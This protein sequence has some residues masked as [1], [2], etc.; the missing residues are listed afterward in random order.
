MIWRAMSKHATHTWQ[1][2]SDR[3][4]EL[5]I[6]YPEKDFSEDGPMVEWQ[7]EWVNTGLANAR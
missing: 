1:T 3:E 6:M 2:A 5:A 4:D 7:K